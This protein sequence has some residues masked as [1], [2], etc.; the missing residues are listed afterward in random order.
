[1]KRHSR[2]LPAIFSVALIR[3]LAKGVAPTARDGF[4]AR[5]I[6]KRWCGVAGLAMLLVAC[7]GGDDASTSGSDTSASAVIPVLGAVSTNAMVVMPPG[8]TLGADKLSIVTSIAMTT[9]ASSGAVTIQSYANGEQLAIARSPAGNPMMMGWIDSTHTTISAKTTAHVL[10]YFALSGSLM[11][12]DVERQTLIADIPKATGI[13]ALEAA[14]QSELVA[15]VD[16]FAKPD[17][18]L[19]QALSVFAVPYYANARVAM[20]VTGRMKAL[21]LVVTPATQSGIDVL[22]DPPFAAH[23]SNTFRRRAFAFVDRVSHTT[24]GVDV[25]DP[26]AVTN[27]EVPPVI[28]VNGGVTGTLTDIMSAYFGNQPTA[29]A[30]ID[31][32]SGGIAVPLV[33][34]SDKTT[35]Q[36][37][38]VGPGVSAGV[39]ASL[40]ATQSAA[41]TDVALRGFVKDFMV[42]TLANA[43]LGSGAIDF[44]AGQGTEKAKFLADVLTSFTTDF[45]AFV[46]TLP[47]LSDKIAM[48]QWFDAGVDITST[49][50]GSNTLRTMLVSGFQKA[51]ARRV[52]AGLDPGPMSGFMASFNTILNAA[53]GVLQVF[54]TGAYVKDLANSDEADQWSVVATASKV[55][56]NPSASTID[57][58]GTVVLMAS[59][60][61]VDNTTG[62]SYHWT[63][64]TQ[65]GDLS[66]IGGGSRTHQTDFCSSSNQALFVYERTAPA[67]TVDTVT[68]QIYG[69]S[70]CDL[71]RG[72]LLGTK[73][74][75][76]TLQPKQQLTISPATFVIA[77]PK[78]TKGFQASGASGLPSDVRFRWTAAKGSLGEPNTNWI[79]NG[80]KQITTTSAAN[81]SV[82]VNFPK[83]GLAVSDTITVEAID[84]AGTVLAIG[85]A[86]ISYGGNP[87]IEIQYF[88]T[89]ANQPIDTDFLDV[90][91]RRS[92]A[93]TTELVEIIVPDGNGGAVFDARLVIA[94]GAFPSGSFT[95]VS[96][97]GLNGNNLVPGQ[98]YFLGRLHSSPING[99]TL[100]IDSMRPAPGGGVF[101]G[102][103][104]SWDTETVGRRVTG[105]GVVIM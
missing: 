64:T 100:T 5:R 53:G 28:G 88:D 47:G 68:V 60:L 69:G 61:G 34:G 75:T 76:V 13:A 49:A 82:P 55:A 84:S 71:A 44:T 24:G 9:P 102:F 7:G 99:G 101:V 27:F 45:V 63:T 37:T 33:D 11:L 3:V 20:A 104:F 77:G 23:L 89:Q 96:A 86:S 30:P 59:V 52:A 25:A 43:V 72:P 38:V 98:G 83:D 42:P 50:A 56:L 16:A 32:P 19:K 17:A 78:L 41:L 57:V 31:V 92:T 58:G 73:P 67:G 12:N 105:N 93:S 4:A 36:V 40:T 2:H 26:L 1:M 39:A 87:Y 95:F 103:S 80:P 51:V 97:S 10:A 46:P 94:K 35:Y 48:G 15:N 85:Q 66:E 79:G 90:T 70:N 6:L 29:Y 74:A 65:F 81:Y 54:D 22:Q 91:S 21:G 14:V 8:V 18:V 62:Y